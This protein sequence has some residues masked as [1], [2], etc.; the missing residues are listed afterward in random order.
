MTTLTA[1]RAIA[2]GWAERST[3]YRDI[4]KGRI[5]ARKRIRRTL[6]DTDDLMRVYG[7]P[8][9]DVDDPH[10]DDVELDVLR[11]ENLRLREDL[12]RERAHRAQLRAMAWRYELTGGL[13][14]LPS[15][16]LWRWLF[17]LES[18]EVASRLS[19]HPR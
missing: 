1:T 7:P 18:F 14:P 11:H 19:L 17:G 5:P 3:L 2:A 13:P 8:A 9:L 10:I 12:D 4:K 16:R 6:V 15:W